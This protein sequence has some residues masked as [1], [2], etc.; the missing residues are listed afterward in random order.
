MRSAES[1]HIVDVADILL[2]SDF[3]N[4]KIATATPYLFLEKFIPGLAMSR[5]GP[6]RDAEHFVPFRDC[7]GQSGHLVSLLAV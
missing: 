6:G 5:N 3:L 7:P 4:N 2:S 1:V